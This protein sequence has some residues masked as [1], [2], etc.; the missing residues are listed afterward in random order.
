M[1]LNR[2]LYYYLII[3][4]FIFFAVSCRTEKTDSLSGSGSIEVNEIH[5]ASIVPGRIEKISVDEGRQFCKGRNPCCN[6]GR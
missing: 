5:I 6:Q 3:Y 4:L 2:K 1:N